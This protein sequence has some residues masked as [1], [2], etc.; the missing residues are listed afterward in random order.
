MYFQASG[1]LTI[2]TVIGPTA[3]DARIFPDITYPPWSVSQV[4]GPFLASC[5][6]CT[7]RYYFREFVSVSHGQ[8][9]LFDCLDFTHYFDIT[10]VMDAKIAAFSE[11]KSQLDNPAEVAPMLT[12]LGA[13]LAA[14]AG[15]SPPIKYVE[16]FM[17]ICN[18]PKCALP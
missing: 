15:V 17:R 1:Q 10:S 3:G 9:Y 16:T 7:V 6:V 13:R 11:H 5:C 12:A 4:G 18:R 14:M 2:A 8:V